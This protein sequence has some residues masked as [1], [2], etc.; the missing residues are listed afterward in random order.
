MERAIAQILPGSVENKNR[1]PRCSRCANYFVTEAGPRGNCTPC[2]FRT[3]IDLPK[4]GLIRQ[5]MKLEKQNSKQNERC[6]Y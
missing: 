4:T 3:E 6:R 2:P 5:A 1:F